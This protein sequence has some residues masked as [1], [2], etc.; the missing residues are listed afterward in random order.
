MKT[1]IIILTFNKL[2]YTKEC[3]ES[4]RMYT[5]KDDYE[6]IIVDNHST[7]G[8]VEWLMEQGDI[9]QIFNSENLGFPKGCNQGIEIATGENIMLLNNDV[10]V[11]K[12]WLTNLVKHLYSR[13]DIGA[14][15]PLTNSCI[16][17]QAI[18]VNYKNHEEMQEFAEKNNIYN[19]TLYEERLKLI[20]FCFLVKK[21]VVEKVGT[22]DEVFTPGNFEDDDLSFRIIKEGYRLLL[23]KDTFI[24][25]YGSITF[26]VNKRPAEY[27][28]LIARNKK[29]I[30]KKW[31]TDIFHIIN[32]RADIVSFI[33]E[34]ADR[35]FNVLQIECGGCGTL[36]KIKDEYKNANLYG[37]E[38]HE[39][40]LINKKVDVN[41]LLADIET[42]ETN[43]GLGFFD[44]IIIAD[45]DIEIEK[46]I[47]VIYKIK[48]YLKEQGKIIITLPKSTN[49]INEFYKLLPMDFDRNLITFRDMSNQF[50]TKIVRRKV[51]N[52]EKCFDEIEN[53]DNV[54]ENIEK[55]LNY[56]K[57]D[58]KNFQII[59]NVIQ[60]YAANKVDLLNIIAVKCYEKG[61]QDFVIPL[62]G[63]VL[64]YDENNKDALLNL[65]TILLQANQ[66]EIALKYIDKINDIDDEV[67]EIRNS[68]L[69]KIDKMN[70]K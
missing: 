3:V 35:K 62:L 12:N 33:N 54:D 4:I 50:V 61:M 55:I 29:I 48:K 66:Y 9:K 21:K 69:E 27:N 11:T 67:Y 15:G 68:I 10:I 24:H 13:E 36:M 49:L 19:A 30:D 58:K 14:V 56:I 45:I 60:K 38:K 8:T 59:L 2:E 17:N 51:N 39:N 47:N 28:K 57:F 70:D 23:C 18:L 26:G 65:A 34:P 25:H 1:S 22:L 7:D 5:M 63:V 41:I 16:Y 44:Y 46:L 6:I 53:N 42:V 20:G 37:I 32:V 52:I 40:T 43:Y 64:E 31:G